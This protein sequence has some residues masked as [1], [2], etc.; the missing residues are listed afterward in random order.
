MKV[1]IPSGMIEMELDNII[2]DME[3]RL[4]YQGM[5]LDQ[6]LQMIGKTQADVRKEYE[7]QAL[8]SIKSRLAIEK[9][10]E[11]EK[12]EATDKEVHEKLEEMAK[13]YGKDVKE[14]EGNENIKDYIATGV[15]TQ[16]AL[17][18]IVE[19]AKFKA[20]KKEKSTDKKEKTT[21]KKEKN[22]AK[23]DKK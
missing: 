22:T 23:K 21:A 8:E 17:E 14:F 19:N 9:I 5:K 15:R 11:L 1:E 12:I 7:A 6:Y 20:P 2:K 10:I 16:K 4:S 18:L 3:Q 13:N